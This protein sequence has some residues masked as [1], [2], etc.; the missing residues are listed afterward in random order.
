M[1]AVF[2]EA[3]YKL[4]YVLKYAFMFVCT[5]SYLSSASSQ[6]LASYIFIFSLYHVFL[7]LALCET[8]TRLF[9]D[10]VSAG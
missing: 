7:N 10:L 8:I 3:L 6:T 2:Y 1:R 4:S 5:A 9:C